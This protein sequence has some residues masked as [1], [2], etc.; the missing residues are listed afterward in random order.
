M[1]IDFLSDLS[2]ELQVA[3]RESGLII[4]SPEQL[5]QQDRRSE[6]LKEKIEHYDLHNL[7]N[8]FFTVYSRRVPVQKWNIHISDKLSNSNKIVELASKLSRGDDVNALLSNRVLKL[9]QSKFADLLLAEWGIH[10]LHF[11][12][13]RSAELLFVYFS[14]SNA[15]FI[16]ILQHEKADGSV[17]TWTNTDLIQVMHDNW[18]HVLRPYIFKTNSNSP[19]LTNDERRTLRKKAATT[20]VIVNDGTEYLPMGGGYSASK[21]PIDAITQSDFLYLTVKQLQMIVENNYPAIQ[22]ALSTYTSSPKLALKLGDNLE[23]MVVEV[24]HNVQLNLLQDTENV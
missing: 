19:I 15:Y 3:L 24:V 8:H 14:G 16:D 9:N 17:V 23:P 6:E 21:H 11:E 22:Q 13:N 7:L 12:E 4:P 10:H 2:G 18:P 5:R 20:T 1:N